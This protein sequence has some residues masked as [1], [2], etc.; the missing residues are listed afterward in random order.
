MANQ[1]TEQA[2]RKFF[3]ALCPNVGFD[4]TDHPAKP[5][6]LAAF[7]LYADAWRGNRWDIRKWDWPCAELERKGKFEGDQP[8]TV[9]LRRAVEISR[10]RA[11][12]A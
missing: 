11:K 4:Y 8:W 2:A 12:A 7:Q 9:L 1:R 3:N 10:Q 5:L 6:V